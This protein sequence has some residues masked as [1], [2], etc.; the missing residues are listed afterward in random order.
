M[1][2]I[3]RVI[4]Y[5]LERISLPEYDYAGSPEAEKAK[6]VVNRGGGRMGSKS[7]STLSPE[8]LKELMRVG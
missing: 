3:E 2:D 8:Q 7:A 1:K 6:A 5:P 4:G